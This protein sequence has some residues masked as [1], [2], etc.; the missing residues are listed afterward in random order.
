MRE[1]GF[2][3]R[4]ATCLVVTACGGFAT[5]ED[6]AFVRGFDVGLDWGVGWG[7]DG[8]VE[9]GVDRGFDEDFDPRFDSGVV[10]GVGLASTTWAAP[11]ALC[12]VDAAEETRSVRRYFLAIA[13]STAPSPAKAM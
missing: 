9:R 4:P 5:A 1:A 3:L 11:R 6:V 12:F 13:G 8:D 2:A 7:V 10:L